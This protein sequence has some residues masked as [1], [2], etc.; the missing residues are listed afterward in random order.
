MFSTLGTVP[1]LPRQLDQ[2]S[3]A[4]FFFGKTESV[5]STLEYTMKCLMAFASPGLKWT[6]WLNSSCL[7]QAC[8]VLS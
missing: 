7:A 5:V 8:R 6:K 3:S 4:V 1:G 2:V